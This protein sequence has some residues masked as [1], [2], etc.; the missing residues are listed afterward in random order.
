MPRLV[1]AWWQGSRLGST[2]CVP[3]ATPS[4]PGATPARAGVSTSQT[5]ARST[6]GRAV[7]RH[8]RTVCAKTTCSPGTTN[9][10]GAACPRPG[11]STGC[12]THKLSVAPQ[13]AE[14]AQHKHVGQGQSACSP[15]RHARKRERALQRRERQ[16]R[17]HFAGRRQR[18]AVLACCAS[19]VRASTRVCSSRA[20]GRSTPK[21]DGGWS[22]KDVGARPISKAPGRRL[23]PCQPLP[24]PNGML[25]ALCAHAK[26]KAPYKPALLW[27][28]PRAL[29][30]RGRA[31]T[32]A[33]GTSTR[34][35]RGAGP[36]RWS[37]KRSRGSAAP[38]PSPRA[39]SAPCAR[40]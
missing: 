11:A 33:L 32:A 4:F 9:S 5:R 31:R 35:R 1:A 8:R 15:A 7:R 26:A 10:C 34:A 17:S 27:K 6:A 23:L 24:G 12:P 29:N 25:S 40:P 28:M 3:A 30:C 13:L 2:P 20:D 36:R 14:G 39:A 38:P 16:G 19:W 18:T 22:P 37:P 21:N